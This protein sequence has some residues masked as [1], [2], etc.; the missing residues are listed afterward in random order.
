MVETASSVITIF[1]IFSGRWFNQ[2]RGGTIG[3]AGEDGQAW[4]RAVVA[5]AS[6]QPA[7]RSA[8]R[9]GRSRAVIT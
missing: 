6:E 1:V 3:C 7:W 4:V 2:V 5:T 8:R 9:R